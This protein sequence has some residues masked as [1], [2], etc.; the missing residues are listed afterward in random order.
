MGVTQKGTIWAGTGGFLG[1]KL[2][3]FDFSGIP[4]NLNPPKFLYKA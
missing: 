2:I 4:K 1:D 3:S